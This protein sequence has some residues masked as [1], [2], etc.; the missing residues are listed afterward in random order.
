ME[1]NV[2]NN[3]SRNII[4]EIIRRKTIKTSDL[5]LKHHISER[6][7][8]MDLDEIDY[9]L[10]ENNCNPLIRN[11]KRGISIEEDPAIKNLIYKLINE[12]DIVTQSYSQEERILEIFYILWNMKGPIK[13]EQLVRLMLVSKSSIVNDIERLKTY[14]PKSIEIKGS[15]E[16]IELFG[17]E[18]EIRSRIVKA[19]INSMSKL[20]VID[21]INLIIK[22]DEKIAY[23]VY[24]RIFEFVD[25][26]VVM[27]I[28]DS[29]KNIY[30]VNLSDI[31]Y[32][33]IM[34]NLCLLIK[35]IQNDRIIT[36]VDSVKCSQITQH[37]IDK[38][39][40]ILSD[41]LGKVIPVQEKHFIQY[42]CYL[43]C[44]EAF[45]LDHTDE[46]KIVEKEYS[47]I[48]SQMQEFKLNNEVSQ[49]LYQDIMNMYCEEK[50]GIVS[51]VSNIGIRNELY[52]KYYQLISTRIQSISFI[53]RELDS[54]D[55]WRIAIHYIFQSTFAEE[56]TKNVLILSDKSETMIEMLI[57]QLNALYDVRI[58]GVTGVAQLQSKL[59]ILPVDVVLSTVKIDIENYKVAKVHPLLGENGINYLKSFL[60]TRPSKDIYNR[61]H[62]TIL[63]FSDIIAYGFDD[64]CRT[65]QNI[66]NEN[67]VKGS[68]SGDFLEH[69]KYGAVSQ[70]LFYKSYMIVQTQFSRIIDHDVFVKL[71]LRDPQ[72][73]DRQIF[74]SFIYIN[75]KNKA[76]YLNYINNLI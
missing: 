8:R 66:L 32:L 7:I 42:V 57:S 71:E 10:R 27:E 3:R 5:A 14:L 16:G 74:S 54:D 29:L 33:Q 39:F 45:L 40:K 9:F 65:M 67:N 72:T 61:H 20:E 17:D 53:E 69:Y 13:I 15:S 56:R 23:M 58:V 24:W 2:L 37:C 22:N 34:G 11:G 46:Q 26:S 6:S 52:M 21:I 55:F 62:D 60:D 25:L 41:H 68:I 76:K 51:P 59:R 30:N 75:C 4:L 48:K 18:Y 64:L 63:S 35:S 50:L 47:S 31:Q 36:A 70:F 28:I 44:P 38:V 49:R 73:F 1:I 12:K 19:Y 43:V